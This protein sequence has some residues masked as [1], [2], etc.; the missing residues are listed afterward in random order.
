MKRKVLH[1]TLCMIACLFF[2][3]F[4][5]KAAGPIVKGVTVFLSNLTEDNQTLVNELAE[6][7]VK[8][9]YIQVKS[10]T[11][12]FPV[13]APIKDFVTKAH[14]AGMKVYM[15]YVVNLDTYYYN[16]NPKSCIYHNPKPPTLNPYPM[17]DNR[18]NLLYPGYKEYVVDNIAFFL[19]E[20]NFD[21]VFLDQLRYNHFVYSF[22]TH[23]NQRAAQLGCDTLKVLGYFNTAANYT[24]YATNNGIID[25]YEARTDPDVNIYYDLR[26]TVL[27]EY[28]TAI[29]DT[30]DVVRPGLTLSAIFNPEFGK[31][32]LCHYAQDYSLQ[33][34]FMDQVWPMAHM[35]TF[36][37][38][39]TDWVGTTTQ[40]ALDLVNGKCDL[41]TYIA[42]TA[43]YTPAI[44][45]EQITKAIAAGSNGIV[46]ASY[47]TITSSSAWSTI[48][49]NFEA[50]GETALN[51]VYADRILSQNSP[52]PFSIQTEIAFKVENQG[53][54]ELNVFDALGRKVSSLVNKNLVPGTYKVN[55]EANGLS[56]GIYFYRLEMDGLNAVR[57]M[58]LKK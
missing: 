1:V 33:T 16:K 21:G 12:E 51:N 50:W 28:L 3:L 30:M 45:N 36:S 52:N 29:R 42:Q 43:S 35:G 4:S 34:E 39:N 17:N 48:K 15:G 7:A 46:V 25:L 41:V 10:A 49:T 27:S 32:A 23:T 18:I 6:N 5:V 9:V 26:K 22:D 57:K 58:V 19:E 14:T 11:G 47:N 54:V 56:D 20:Y 40:T 24:T 37:Q 31:A 8:D 38:S 44:L 55:F 53:K 2:N 13:G